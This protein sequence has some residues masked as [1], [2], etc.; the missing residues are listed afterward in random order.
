MQP[1]E[2]SISFRVR[3]P[4]AEPAEITREL[5]MEPSRTWKA[6]DARTTPVGTPLAG[7][8][9][10]TYWYTRLCSLVAAA[11]ESL[12]SALG[13][14]LGRLRAHEQFLLRMRREA[15]GAEFYI[16][17]NGPGNFGFEFD[18]VLL[19]D[20]ASMGITLSLEIFPVPQNS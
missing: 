2:Y 18:P 14:F 20:L 9:A 1:Y 6:G 15:G 8:Y 13:R 7:T 19:T 3:H 10:E 5:Q 4:S 17:V 12:E 16:G 11:D